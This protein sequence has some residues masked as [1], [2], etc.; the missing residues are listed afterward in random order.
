MERGMGIF[1]Y[2]I[3][4]RVVIVTRLV[5]MLHRKRENRLTAKLSLLCFILTGSLIG[6]IRAW[7]GGGQGRVTGLYG[8][9]MLLE[10]AGGYV[11]VGVMAFIL[12]VVI[13]V[14][15]IRYRERRQ[16]I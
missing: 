7:G 2:D 14:L 9:T 12:A 13:T 16:K 8:T 11:L 3:K 10:D 4:M 5:Y 15:C 6:V 1:M